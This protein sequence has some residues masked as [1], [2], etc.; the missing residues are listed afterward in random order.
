M[1]FTCNRDNSDLFGVEKASRDG[2]KILSIGSIV[3]CKEIS[4]VPYL[5][6]CVCCRYSV[7]MISTVCLFVVLVLILQIQLV[8]HSIHLPGQDQRLGSYE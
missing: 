4:L 1:A 2:Q 5:V 8:L 7:Y 6:H 3:S